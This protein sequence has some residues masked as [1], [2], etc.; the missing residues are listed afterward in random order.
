VDPFLPPTSMP[1]GSS[2]SNLVD[3][4]TS[5]SV[6][7]RCPLLGFSHTANVCSICYRL[8]RPD[9]WCVLDIWWLF[10]L[11]AGSGS[12]KVCVVQKAFHAAFQSMLVP[13]DTMR[14]AVHGHGLTL[15]VH[16]LWIPLLLPLAPIA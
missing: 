3:C 12:G 14:L 5:T 6:C 7:Q 10:L 2:C 11:Q 8:S 1:P 15:K 9:D 4:P 16:A 13:A